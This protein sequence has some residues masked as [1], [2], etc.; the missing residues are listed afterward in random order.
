MVFE[1]D[2]NKHRYKYLWKQAA[3]AQ[4]KERCAWYASF[5][6]QEHKKNLRYGLHYTSNC[7]QWTAPKPSFSLEW[8]AQ[9]LE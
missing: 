2:A 3:R 7:R 4:A 5:Q 6:K 8:Q 1:S 9:H